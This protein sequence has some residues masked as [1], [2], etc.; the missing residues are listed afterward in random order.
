MTTQWK[1]GSKRSRKDGIYCFFTSAVLAESFSNWH[2]SD[3]CINFNLAIRIVYEKILFKVGFGYAC[4]YFFLVLSFSKFVLEGYNYSYVGTFLRFSCIWNLLEII[5][6]VIVKVWF[7]HFGC[8]SVLLTY[9][10]VC[11]G[12]NACGSI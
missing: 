2:V 11:S 7:F 10:L 6:F 12:I 1:V 4:I 8:F 3:H 5:V 9:Q